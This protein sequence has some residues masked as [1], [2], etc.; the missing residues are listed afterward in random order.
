MSTGNVP[1]SLPLSGSESSGNPARDRKPLSSPQALPSQPPAPSWSQFQILKSRL[2]TH[3]IWEVLHDQSRHGARSHCFDSS[4]NGLRLPPP[5]NFTLPL[6]APP[7]SASRNRVTCSRRSPPPPEVGAAKESNPR[8]LH[9]PR[10]GPERLHSA[11][12]QAVR[13]R[14]ERPT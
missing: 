13:R 9:P 1:R 12:A 7:S 4:T 2:C 10:G 3:P 6:W 8:K 14:L 11:Q 5:P